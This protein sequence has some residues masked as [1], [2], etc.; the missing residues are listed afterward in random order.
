MRTPQQAANTNTQR[1]TMS[2]FGSGMG[3]AEI[4]ISCSFNGFS[5]GDPMYGSLDTRDTT[6]VDMFNGMPGAS[7]KNNNANIYS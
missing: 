5:Y 1:G 7:Y 6:I 4:L 2:G 3:T